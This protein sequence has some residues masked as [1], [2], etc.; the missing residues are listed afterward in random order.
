MASRVTTDPVS[1]GHQPGDTAGEPAQAEPVHYAFPSPGEAIAHQG[2]NYYI[3]KPIGQGYYGIVYDCSDDWGSELVAKVLK[4]MGSFQEVADR[5]QREAAVLTT[6][7]HPNITYIHDA[8]VFRNLFYLVIEKCLYPLSAELHLASELWLPQ[9]ARDVLQAMAY[10]HRAGWVHKDIHVGNVFVSATKDPFDES[11]QPVIGFKLGDFGISRM[12]GSIRP[13]GSELAM[14]TLPPEAIDPSLGPIDRRVDIYHAGLLF[15][16]V[17]H[18]R[19]LQ[20]GQEQIHAGV[21]AQMAADLDSI[22]APALARA[23]APD[24]KR[25]TPTALDL[26]RDISACM[27]QEKKT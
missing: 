9:L 26:W 13:H 1:P 5:W 6:M 27:H 21:P 15:L 18:G 25:R 16:M 4:P 17:I 8:F 20:F 3:G 19:I 7:R 23:L 12:E 11:R 2:A 24:A 14:W 22:Y 10:I